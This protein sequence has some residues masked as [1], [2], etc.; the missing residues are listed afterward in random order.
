MANKRRTV[1]EAMAARPVDLDSGASPRPAVDEQ[2]GKENEIV[3]E[4]SGRYRD[5]VVKLNRMSDR[6]LDRA[7]RRQ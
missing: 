6:D 2:S 7:L 5:A 4:S 3:R 1:K